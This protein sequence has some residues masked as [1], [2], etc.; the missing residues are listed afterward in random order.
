MI[1]FFLYHAEIIITSVSVVIA[2]VL[3]IAVLVS[4]YYLYTPMADFIKKHGGQKIQDKMSMTFHKIMRK[5]LQEKRRRDH[6]KAKYH[7]KAKE[8]KNISSQ[9][10]AQDIFHE[11]V[12]NEI[13]SRMHNPD[14]YDHIR[15]VCSDKGDHII[16]STRFRGKKASGKVVLNTVQAKVDLEGNVLKI[17]SWKS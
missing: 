5:L 10:D 4:C 9:F 17:I 6:L 7:Q 11:N 1:D 8:N 16:V 2:L 15:T 14:S 3:I 13:K 12:N